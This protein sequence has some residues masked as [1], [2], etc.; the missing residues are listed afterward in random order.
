[1]QEGIGGKI[2]LGLHVDGVRRP[3]VDEM[4]RWLCAVEFNIPAPCIR[5]GLH[6]SEWRTALRFEPEPGGDAEGLILLEAELVA[7][8]DP[9]F[10]FEPEALRHGTLD[11]GAL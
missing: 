11:E 3:F 9:A 2:F 1:M 5:A 10:R 7:V 6:F 4:D 8:F